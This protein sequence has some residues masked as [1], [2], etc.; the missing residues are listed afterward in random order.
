EASTSAVSSTPFADF[1]NYNMSFQQ[2]YPVPSFFMNQL[3]LNKA[4][5]EYKAINQENSSSKT[6][7]E[8]SQL[9]SDD[10]LT[11]DT[12]SNS[13]EVPSDKP[14]KRWSSSETRILI[15]EVGKQYKTLQKAKDPREKGRIW[16]KIISGIQSSTSNLNLKERS[17][18]SVQQKW[19][20]IH[21]KYRNIK[22]VIKN[23]GEEAIQNEWE[24]FNDIDSKKKRSIRTT[25]EKKSINDI[26][27]HIDKQTELIVDTIK[28]QYLHTSEIQQQQHNEQITIS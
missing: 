27:T 18:T 6:K 7:L 1:T 21:Q 24:F 22:D 16:N 15:E 17:K 8:A 23:T 26:L 20:S 5:A 11:S 12:N 9:V 19:E 13:S 10:D 28:E 3:A 25:D 4:A 2:Q 14:T